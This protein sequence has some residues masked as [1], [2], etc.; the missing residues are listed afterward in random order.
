[1]IKP[2]RVRSSLL[3]VGN[4]KEADTHNCIRDLVLMR[5]KQGWAGMSPD[6][7]VERPLEGRDV[8]ASGEI[9]KS[10]AFGRI[11]ARPR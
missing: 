11:K 2:D 3:V 8:S 4:R 10:Q 6:C 5:N 9:T 7:T 1:M